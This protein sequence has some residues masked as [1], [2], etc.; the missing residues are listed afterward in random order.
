[1]GASFHHAM[2]SLGTN[3]SLKYILAN[4]VTLIFANKTSLSVVK[5]RLNAKLSLKIGSVKKLFC[6]DVDNALKNI[7][8][9]IKPCLSR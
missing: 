8:L 9:G 5:K 1:M 3:L 4:Y 7:F 6:F 2:L